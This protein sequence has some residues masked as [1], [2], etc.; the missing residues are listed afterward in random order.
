MAS[1]KLFSA[2]P[3]L[4]DDVSVAS[5]Y[6]ISL[7]ELNAEDPLTARNVLHACQELGFFS[8]YTMIP[9]AKT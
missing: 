7:V 6:T 9:S 3:R 5:M 4:P 1:E 2:L 8:T